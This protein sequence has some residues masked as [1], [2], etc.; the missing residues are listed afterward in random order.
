MIFCTKEKPWKPEMGTPCQHVDAHEDGDQRD[1]YPGG[2][3]ITMK[4]PNCGVSW[5]SELPQ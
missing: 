1:G 2:D 5:K 3:I 4:C